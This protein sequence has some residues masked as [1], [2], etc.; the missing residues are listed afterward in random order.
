[1]VLT[2]LALDLVTVPGLDGYARANE[3]QPPEW[4][5]AEKKRGSGSR[6]LTSIGDAVRWRAKSYAGAPLN[7]AACV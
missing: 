4:D 6:I 5:G 3:P 1:M 2:I 7:L